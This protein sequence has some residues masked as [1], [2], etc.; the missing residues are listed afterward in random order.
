MKSKILLLPL[1]ISVI[2]L[3]QSCEVINKD[4][5]Y[6]VDS[7]SCSGC[8]NCFLVCPN[9]AIRIKNSKAVIDLTKCTSCGRCVD[10]CPTNAIY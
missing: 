2:L 9:D 8:N 7:R 3:I 4:A 6:S 5:P 1:L 10:A